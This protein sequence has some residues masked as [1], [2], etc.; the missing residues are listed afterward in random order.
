MRREHLEIQAYTALRVVAGVLFACHGFQHVFG[1]F[2]TSDPVGSELWIGG[3][4]Q[5]ITGPLIAMGLFTRLS[6]FFAAGEMAV[7]YF[8]YEWGF[9]FDR[10]LVPL[11]NGGDLAIVN[12]FV[13]L[14]IYVR[15]GGQISVDRR[16][17][18]A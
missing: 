4:I 10:R 9:H 7:A 5:L 3:V 18:R 1:A 16:L 8:Q 14:F 6:A 17:D 12:C 15:G 2:G 11:G 13:F